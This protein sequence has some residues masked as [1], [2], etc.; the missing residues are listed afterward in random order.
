MNRP[1]NTGLTD[2]GSGYDRQDSAP[3]P[4]DGPNHQ[5]H[6]ENQ[7]YQPDII[8]GRPSLGN[9]YR[10]NTRHSW[11]NTVLHAQSSDV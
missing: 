1:S 8:A 5:R 3:G 6:K 11:H 2:S 4:N 9:T 10:A 7:Q